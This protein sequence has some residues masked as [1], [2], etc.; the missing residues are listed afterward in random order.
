MVLQGRDTV[1]K[2]DIMR[3]IQLVILPRSTVS[4][5]QQDQ[6]PPP[7]QPP[8]PPPPPSNEDKQ[9]E[10]EE[11]EEEDD[12]QEEEP[13]E[14]EEEVSHGGG[15]RPHPRHDG[16]SSHS[17]QTSHRPAAGVHACLQATL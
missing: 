16:A 13:P 9:E 10:K 6:E 11:E 5:Q 4:D 17:C 2:E 7:N 3:A 14:E 1:S 8:P 12:D 15:C